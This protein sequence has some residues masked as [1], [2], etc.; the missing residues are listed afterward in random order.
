MVATV[1]VDGSIDFGFSPEAT[2]LRFLPG[3]DR[4]NFREMPP[5]T[6]LATTVNGTNRPLLARSH[7]GRDVS[8]ECFDYSDNRIVT[9]RPL[10]PAMLSTD[11]EIVRQDCLCYLMERIGLDEHRR[12]AEADPDQSELPE[13]QP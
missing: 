7:D 3:L 8:A 10:M 12:F 2:E 4:L 6:R 13:T 5:G 1:T 11:E 9:R